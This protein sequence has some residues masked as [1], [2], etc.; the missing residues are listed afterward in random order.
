MVETSIFLAG[1]KAVAAYQESAIVEGFDLGRIVSLTYYLWSSIKIYKVYRTWSEGQFSNTEIISFRW[2][3][4]FLYF[5]GVW[6]ACC[7]IDFCNR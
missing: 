5:M 7:E 6:I 3:R 4:N 1:G 2:F